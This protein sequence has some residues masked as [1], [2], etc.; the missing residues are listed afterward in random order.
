MTTLAPSRPRALT[1]SVAVLTAIALVLP[2]TPALA[3]SDDASAKASSAPADATHAAGEA[4]AREVAA[5]HGHDVVIDSLTTPTWLVTA[6]PDGYLEA[7]GSQVPEQARVGEKWK[8]IDTTLVKKPGGYEPRVASVPV[9]VG[10]GGSDE[11]VS[12]RSESGEWVTEKWPYG[13]LP[14]PRVRD[15]AAVFEEVLPGVDLR[16][17]ATN[18]GI[19]EVLIVK[20]AE[21]AKDDRVAALRLTIR[22]ARLAESPSAAGLVAHVEDGEPLV[23][24]TPLWWDSS[25]RAAGAESPASA[26]A[27]PLGVAVVGEQAVLDVASVLDTDL[28]YPLYI[29]PDWA[30]GLQAYWYTDRA[31]PNERYLNGPETKVG[32]GIQNGVAY[33]PARTTGSTRRR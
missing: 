31:F 8:P 28:S 15:D 12:I 22:G 27:Q 24:S 5:A 2:S 13:A 23:S 1:L 7:V 33:Y 20:N 14:A 26:E 29:D 4:L 16:V 11:I 6:R 18:A 21:A 3:S 19:R 30:S 10:L 17:A 9:R 25:H 32:N